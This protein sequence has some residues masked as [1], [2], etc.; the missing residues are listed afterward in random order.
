VIA[1]VVLNAEEI[2]EVE[3]NTAK[4]V[5]YYY[6]PAIEMPMLAAFAYRRA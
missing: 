4:G 1:N 5:I 6:S 2:A 3:K